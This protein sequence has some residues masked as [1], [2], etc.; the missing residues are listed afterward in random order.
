[1]IIMKV[2]I[3]TLEAMLGTASNNK[4]LHADFIASHAPDAKSREE[5]IEAVGVEEVVEKAMTVFPRN[6]E[7][8]PI[9]WDY[10]IKGFFK[11]ACGSLRKIKG[12]ESSKIKAYKKEID[13]LIFVDEREILIQTDEPIRSCQRP[14]RAATPQGERISLANSEE[15]AAGAILEFPIRVMA[16]DLAPAVKE[17][18]SYGKLR[19]L[20][21]WRNSGKGR[22]SCTILEQ[23]KISVADMLEPCAEA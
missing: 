18:L 3:S 21:Q 16:D 9:M 8:K 20:G 15:I 14:L 6:K 22:F 5:E 1:M 4:E 12:T 11:D 10:Q 23:E 13:G 19:G 7:G 17:W 2:R